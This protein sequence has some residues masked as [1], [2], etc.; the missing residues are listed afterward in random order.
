MNIYRA[1]LH[2]GGKTREQVKQQFDTPATE[3]EIDETLEYYNKL[4]GAT[5]FVTEGLFKSYDLISWPE[6]ESKRM[7]EAIYLVEQDSMFGTY[8][9]QREEFDADWEAGNYSPS[10]ILTFD[11]ADV[12]IIAEIKVKNHGKDN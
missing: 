5:V 9:D 4:D 8:I 6:E 1:T 11:K 7:K 12:E 2:T 3:K 10:G